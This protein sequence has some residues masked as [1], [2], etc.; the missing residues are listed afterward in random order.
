MGR[1]IYPA[2]SG[3]TRA[4]HMLDVLSN[5]LANVNTTGFKSDRAVFTLTSP[6]AAAGL[7][8][9]SAEARLAAAWNS[10]DGEATDF[11]QGTLAESGIATHLALQGEGFFQVRVPGS[12]GAVRL[13][14]DGSF[15]VDPD[16]YLATRSGA[17][18]L[19][20]EGEAI[21]VPPGELVIADSG[22]LLVAGADVGTLGIVDVADRSLLSKVGGNFWELGAGQKTVAATGVSVLQYSLEGS[23]VEPVRALTELITISRYYEAFK[24]SLESSDELDQMLNTTVG[25]IDR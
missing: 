8:P 13:T 15:R 25:R 11:S 19:N 7:D 17:R 9:A 6:A 16:G 22:T 12:D 5:N 4:L 24:K 23:N 21:E 20:Q 10:L 1:E 3:G 18:V 2:M 14:R